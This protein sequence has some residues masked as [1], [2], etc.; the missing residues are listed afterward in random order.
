MIKNKRVGIGTSGGINSAAIIVWLVENLI[1]KGITPLELHLIY[2]HINQHSPD[3]LPF[4]HALVEYTRKYFPDTVYY[5]EN[6]D[7]LEFFKKQNMIP[8]PTADT[9]T[10]LIKTER[11]NAYKK[12]N[13]IDL[14]LI[15]YVRTERTRIKTF[16]SRINNIPKDRV[17]VD[18]VI[19]GGLSNGFFEE[20]LFPIAKMSDEECF[21]MVKEYI[22]WYPAIYDILWTDER[23]IPFLDSVKDQ[24]PEEA[25]QIALNYAKQGFGFSK[26]KRVFNHNNC[27]LC[28]NM[29]T[30]QMWMVKLFYPTYF[31][32]SIK[33]AQEIKAYWGRSVDDMY[34]SFGREDYEVGFEEQSCGVCKFG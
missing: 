15:G 18:A 6:N 16:A 13:L 24:M 30:W 27:L 2:I 14:D 9:C 22:G 23:I 19:E 31:E 28:K 25:R 12:Q 26:T 7:I 17:N 4:V 29:Q 10:R 33:T 5:Q 8:H 11:I 21:E 1:K 34:M 3:T 32:A 20:I